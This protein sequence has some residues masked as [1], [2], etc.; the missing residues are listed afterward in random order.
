MVYLADFGV[1]DEAGDSDGG[2]LVHESDFGD[3]TG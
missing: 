2:G 1:R 3:Q